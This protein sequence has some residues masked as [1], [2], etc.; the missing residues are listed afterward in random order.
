MN[1]AA[2]LLQSITQDVRT[3]RKLN[4]A[5]PDL[6][7]LLGSSREELGKLPVGEETKE[8]LFTEF[9]KETMETL[10]FKLRKGGFGYVTKEETDY[11]DALRV[12]PDPPMGLYY[13]G[14]FPS[15]RIPKL[16]VVGT[17]KCTS[18]GSAVAEYFSSE[19]A[20]QGVVIVSGLANGIDGI[21]HRGALKVHGKT[22]AVLGSGIGIPYPKENWKT[23]HEIVS[24]GGLIL[25]EY[26][27][28]C[29]P[30]SH[31]FPLRNRILSGISD[32]VL[33]VEAREKSGTMITVDCA[34]EQGKDVFVIPGRIDEENSKGCNNLIKQGARLVTSPEEILEE[35]TAKYPFFPAE[36]GLRSETKANENGPLGD[37]ENGLASEKKMVYSFVRLHLKHFDV[38]VAETKINPQTL[39]AILSEL[40]ASG[41]ITEPVPNYYARPYRG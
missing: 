1:A 14:V 12:I 17:R 41:L 19:L 20:R 22:V 23:Y 31:H 28:E 3:L 6:T 35:L 15:E 27:P 34:L 8:K 16:A 4:E 13:E 10:E 7:K 26:P 29:P 36:Q 37:L 32:A 24:S 9:R 39:L 5:V 25:S 40:V 38:L 2:A 11:P 33:V 21:A 30:L 18:Y